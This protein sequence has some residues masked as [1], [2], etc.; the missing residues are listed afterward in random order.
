MLGMLGAAPR[1]RR[2]GEADGPSPVEMASLLVREG[3]WTR[4][5]EVLAEIDPASKGVD[6]IRY[7]TLVGLVR[8]HDK[9]G[10]EAVD[11][12][13]AALASAEEGRELLEL[14]LARAYVAAGRPRDALD[15][16]DRAG[17][18]GAGLAGTWLLRAQAS[19]EAGDPDA[20]WDA[21]VDGAARFPAAVDLQRQQVFLLVRLGLFR[22]ARARGESLLARPDADADD[23]VAISEALRRGGDTEQALVILEAALL[24]EGE[25]RDLLVQ[26]A[27]ASL[28]AGQP[29]NAARFLERAAVLDPALALESAEA[30]RRAGDLLNAERLNARVSDP[31]AKARQRLGLL[32]DAEAWERAVALEERL[33]RL[34]LAGDDGVAYGIAYAWFRLGDHE[35]VEHWLADIRDPEAFRRAGALRQAMATCE[36]QGVCQ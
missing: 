34:D 15:A 17:E 12:F 25:D 27:R 3:D 36:E 20:A 26:A 30:Y 33:E 6:S 19:E 31:R 16:L 32:L 22:E 13:V 28:D 9:Q 29:R 11:A 7:F 1:G 4:A 21:L 24:E 10:A 23:A 8:L 2:D 18:V 35:R 5:G 14:H